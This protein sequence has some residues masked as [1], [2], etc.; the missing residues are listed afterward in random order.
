VDGESQ[1]MPSMLKVAKIVL[2]L[3]H[4]GRD[5]T[6]QVYYQMVRYQLRLLLLNLREKPL[7]L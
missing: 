4:V 5:L 3:W 2:Q 1:W 6:T 7:H